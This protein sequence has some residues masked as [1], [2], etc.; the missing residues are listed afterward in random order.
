CSGCDLLERAKEEIKQENKIFEEKLNK[1]N[2]SNKEFESISNSINILNTDLSANYLGKDTLKGT[3][4]KYKNFKELSLKL[5]DINSKLNANKSRINNINKEIDKL[6]KDKEERTF[7]ISELN[8]KILD[9]NSQTSKIRKTIETLINNKELILEKIKGYDLSMDESQLLA[10]RDKLVQSLT[11]IEN[12]KVTYKNIKNKIETLLKEESELKIDYQ[13]YNR[14]CMAFDDNLGL[15]AVELKRAC[16]SIETIVNDLL[17]TIF[18]DQF[19]IKFITEGTSKDDF[20]ITVTIKNRPETSLSVLSTG[21]QIIISIALSLASV[22]YMQKDS[23]YMCETMFLDEI[24]SHLNKDRIK[25]VFDLIRI[26]HEQ[27]LC[28]QTIFITHNVN[29]LGT[30]PRLELS[31][32][33]EKGYKYIIE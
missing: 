29:E 12:E 30:V 1:I 16:L 27:S 6:E 9:L 21:E 26:A 25:Y 17:Q 23:K 28:K 19:K 13:E 5:I 3:E 14:L 7:K 33:E 10:E 11:I 4:E 24:D 15:P 8:D 18:K 22:I 2:F 32:K 20:D 31:P